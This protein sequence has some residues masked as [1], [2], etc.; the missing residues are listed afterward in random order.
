MGFTSRPRFTWQL[1]TRSLALGERTLLMGIVNVTPDSFSDGGAFLSIPLAVDR[2]LALLDQ[3]ADVLDL[4][5]ESTRPNATPVPPA[6]EQERVLPVLAALLRARPDAIVSIDTHHAITARKAVELGAEIVNDVSGLRWDS[7]MAQTLA[8]LQPGVVLMH[9]RGHPQEWSGLPALQTKEVLPLVL[10]GLRESL[11]VARVHGIPDMRIVLD[12][13]FGF[14]KRGDENFV[15]HAKFER[16]H[17]LGFPLLAGTSRKRFL[18]AG[19]VDVDDGFR[20]LATTASNVASTLAG[21]HLLRVHDVA[22]AHAA[23]SVAD[24]IL[25]AG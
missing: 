20:R 2:A 1:R 17:T 18:N 14:G 12:P 23:A 21:A 15:L 3:G 16:L 11:S 24:A 19:L 9:T 6:Q 10:S 13:G 25:R 22:S 4:G 8:D 7:G 5:G